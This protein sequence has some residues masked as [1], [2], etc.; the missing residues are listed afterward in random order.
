M[1]WLVYDEK[2]DELV[3]L[4]WVGTR[5]GLQKELHDHIKVIGLVD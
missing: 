1:N 4:F 2:N 5:D 3:E